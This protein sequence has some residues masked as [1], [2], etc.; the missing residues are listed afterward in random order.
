[1]LT[2]GQSTRNAFDQFSVARAA[3]VHL[4]RQKKAGMEN[5]VFPSRSEPG[6]NAQPVPIDRAIDYYQSRTREL[7]DAFDA[8]NGTDRFKQ[9]VNTTDLLASM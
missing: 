1:M 8:R 9:I 4:A 5:V 2:R 7:A 6:F 3:W